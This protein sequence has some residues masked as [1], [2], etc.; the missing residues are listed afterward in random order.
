MIL[1]DKNPNLPSLIA[2]YQQNPTTYHQPHLSH[3]PANIN[4]QAN[5][6]EDE[7]NASG[8]DAMP[9]P[10]CLCDEKIVDYDDYHRKISGGTMICKFPP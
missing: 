1:F 5:L 3:A 2:H 10:Q 4:L 7:E 8:D 6:P 9:R